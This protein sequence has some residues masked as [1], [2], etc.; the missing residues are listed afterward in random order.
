MAE[1]KE[2]PSGQMGDKFSPK[3]ISVAKACRARHGEGLFGHLVKAAC[4]P[5]TCRS[6]GKTRFSRLA[7]IV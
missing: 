4:S 6:E 7:K 3:H 2:W 5:D 1:F